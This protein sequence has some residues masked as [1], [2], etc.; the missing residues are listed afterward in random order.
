M[1]GAAKDQTN[2]TLAVAFI[3][4]DGLCFRSFVM[5]L[6][7]S[8]RYSA[9]S[10][11]HSL[12]PLRSPQRLGC[13]RTD[14]LVFVPYTRRNG[15][16]RPLNLGASLAVAPAFDVDR[17]RST[18]AY[19][20]MLVVLL[21]GYMHVVIL[22]GSLR[23][24]SIDVGR[25]MI[26]GIMVVLGL[27]GNVLGRVRRNFYLG[28]RTPWTLA[29]ERVWIETHRLA[30]WVMVTASILGLLA[31]VARVPL[32]IIFVAYIG[33][34]AA[35]PVGYS[36]WLYRRLDRQGKLFADSGADPLQQNS[37]V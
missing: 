21:L 29:S 31:L 23:A 25:W 27:M 3:G 24:D 8:V 17:F 28:V 14:I 26:G 19:V 18:Y 4:T 34:I 30:A 13:P 22:F 12:G 32:A 15:I 2:E 20:M 33:T 7:V 1:G 6:L 36:W 11:A 16:G 37:A 5:D 9:G 10:T 35:L